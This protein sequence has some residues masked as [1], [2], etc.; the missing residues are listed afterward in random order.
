MPDS[1][2]NV[3]A[4]ATQAWNITTLKA[5]LEALVA[6]LAAETDLK[7][8]ARDKAQALQFQADQEHFRTLNHEAAR[9]LKATEITVSRD[10]WDAFKENDHQWKTHVE[11]RLAGAMKT[12]EFNIYKETTERALNLG[13]GKGQGI[14]QLIQTLA[15][16][17][18]IVG[19]AIVLLR[20]H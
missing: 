13:A 4:T 8:E 12:A 14:W 3:N 11:A 5:Y 7:F 15:S 17:A 9:I 1:A 18:A 6:A 16:L 10:T 2:Q 19:V 20:P